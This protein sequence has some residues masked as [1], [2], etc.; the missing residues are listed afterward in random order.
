MDDLWKGLQLA[1]EQ[2]DR[3]REQIE[4]FKRQMEEMTALRSGNC[5]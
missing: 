5:V 2:V 1:P 3:L 4:H